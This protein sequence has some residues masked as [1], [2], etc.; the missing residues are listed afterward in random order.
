MFI[1]L[2][3]NGVYPYEYKDNWKKFNETSIPEKENLYSHLN[4]ED[5]TD[6]DYTA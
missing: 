6:A 2:V 1:L 5:I 3:V 4:I